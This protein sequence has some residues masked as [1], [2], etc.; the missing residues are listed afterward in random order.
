MR[1]PWNAAQDGRGGGQVRSLN[2]LQ[3]L[4]LVQ[5]L[6]AATI[7]RPFSRRSLHQKWKLPQR[8]DRSG[9]FKGVA[10]HFGALRH[11]LSPSRLRRTTPTQTHSTLCAVLW[12]DSELIHNF[13]SD[14]AAASPKE[15]ISLRQL[16]GERPPFFF[17]SAEG[18]R[19][20]GSD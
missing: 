19:L 8:T 14:K 16:C 11:L 17:G 15:Q 18:F 9:H 7:L 3:L 13:G 12:V 10:R 2:A 6:H 5:L 20:Q 1:S 4:D